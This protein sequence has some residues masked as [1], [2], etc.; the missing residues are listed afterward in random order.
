ML[1]YGQADSLNIT[2]LVE[3]TVSYGVHGLK[4]VHGVSC[5]VE[6]T[7]GNLTSR[8]LMDVGSDPEI[9]FH[10]MD[11]LGLSPTSIDAIV[12]THCHWDHTRGLAQVVKRIGKKNLPVV[13]HPAIY[14]SVFS[15]TPRL[16]YVGVDHADLPGAVEEEGG[17]FLLAKDPVTIA[18]GLSTTGEIQRLTDFEGSGGGIRA[19]NGSITKDNMPDDISLM[20]KVT[21]QG[22]V[23]L[24]GC[25]HAGIVNIVKQ[26]RALTG[27]VPVAGVIGGFHLINADE[28]RIASTVDG[29]MQTEARLLS[30]GH[31]TGFEAQY[32]LRHAFGERFK[33]MQCGARYHFEG[34][35]I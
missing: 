22:L 31:C 1:H 25:A 20:A 10:N 30:A 5:L 2:V 3:D 19:E 16:R 8:T 13:A 17:V 34:S 28:K 26:A 14:R 21:G 29:L 32:A 18:D 15:T 4:A 12:L 35:R 27:Q 6:T 9:L 11:V 23:V 33:P 7:A 24:T